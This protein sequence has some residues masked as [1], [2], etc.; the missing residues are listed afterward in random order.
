MRLKS[1]A[2]LLVDLG[3]EL[4]EPALQALDVVH[5]LQPKAKKSSVSHPSIPNLY[6]RD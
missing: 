1:N 5:S 4:V 3:L 6:A 2:D